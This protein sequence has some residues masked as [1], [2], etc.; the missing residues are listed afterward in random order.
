M[1]PPDVNFFILFTDKFIKLLITEADFCTFY[2]HR[3]WSNFR[4]F[5]T[6]SIFS[7]QK[8]L[9]QLKES[10]KYKTSILKKE[11]KTEIGKNI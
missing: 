10:Y 11:S 7:C 3:D 9:N 1:E 5:M 6:Y 2:D 4:V 8:K